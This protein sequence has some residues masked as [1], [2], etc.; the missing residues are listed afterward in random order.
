MKAINEEFRHIEAQNLQIPKLNADSDD[1][2]IWEVQAQRPTL[3]LG[4]VSEERVRVWEMPEEHIIFQKQVVSTSNY[5]CH[6]NSHSTPNSCPN[7]T[8]IYQIYSVSGRSPYDTR[9]DINTTLGE[10]EVETT[11]F[12]HS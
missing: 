3:K 2:Q 6:S 7:L 11:T 5:Y 9:I 8:V 1:L 12:S 4:F 10:P